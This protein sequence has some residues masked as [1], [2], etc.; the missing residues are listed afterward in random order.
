MVGKVI[1]N[2]LSNSSE[3]TS[4]IGTKIYPSVS[5]NET[6]VNYIVYQ[7]NGT[8][9]V[10]CKDG[11]STLDILSY[12]IL[13]FSETLDT[14]NSVAL[15]V[16][17]T[18]DHYSGVNSGLTID[19]IIYEGESDDFDDD[20]KIYFKSVSYQIRFKNIYSL[21][22]RPTN[23]TLTPNGTT[24]IDLAWTDNATGETGYKVYRSEDL[25]N[26]TL[27][28]TI[29]AN[30]VSYSDTTVTQ[31]KIYYYYVVAY[32]SNGN[33]YASDVKAQRTN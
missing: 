27:I 17:N 29:A 1:Y 28:N 10:N 15:G 14:L 12:D 5:F 33:G 25:Q 16:R 9:P 23:L 26:F 11:R 19:K 3:L 31:N 21:L 22:S 4:L 2:L 7:K 20:S 24:Q 8:E 30:S 18:L 6:A 32:V 13:I